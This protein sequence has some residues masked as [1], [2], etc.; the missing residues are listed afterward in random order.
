MAPVYDTDVSN[1]RWSKEQWRNYELWE[2]VEARL[3]RQRR[4][5]VFAACAVF[6]GLLSVPVFVESLPHWRAIAAS[7]LLSNEISWMK[8]QVALSHKAMQLRFVSDTDYVIEMADRCRDQGMSEIR[9]GKLFQNGGFM[10]IRPEQAAEL[11]L[12]GL[13]DRFC[14]DP[15]KGNAI[16]KQTQQAVGFALVPA[17]DLTDRHGERRLNRVA[18][19]LLTGPSAEIS[20]D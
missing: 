17:T 6:V 11:G 8:H 2:K 3:R 20:F 7:R 12:S 10:V 1:D 18:V 15:Y 4:T 9:S 5:W 14:F 13:V 16:Y 19:T